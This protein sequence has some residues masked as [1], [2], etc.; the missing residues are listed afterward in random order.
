MDRTYA[1]VS[2]EQRRAARR[3]ALA[4]AALDLV[5]DGGWERV[6]VRAV[7]SRARLNDRYFYESFTDRD[8]LLLAVFD[9]IAQGGLQA[10]LRAIEDS[11]PDLAVRVRAVVE[12]VIG[13]FVADPRRGHLVFAAREELRSRRQDMVRLLAGIVAD[14][15]AELLGDRAAAEPDRTLGAVTMVSGTMEVFSSWLRGEV[16]VGRE[17]LTDFLVAMLLTTGDLAAALRRERD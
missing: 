15:S 9:D 4:E 5:A 12:A 7:C 10:F 16:D 8:A 6:T 2:G 1:G 11:S 13:Y 14:Q 3:A 17:H